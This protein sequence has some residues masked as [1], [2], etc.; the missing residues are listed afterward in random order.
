[1]FSQHL[2]SSPYSN[3]L[4][5]L[6][7]LG[8]GDDAY[9]VENLEEMQRGKLQGGIQIIILH[10]HQWGVSSRKQQTVQL[11]EGKI[12]SPTCRDIALLK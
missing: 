11:Q 6:S 1:M 7:L 3:D 8:N 5:L 9:Q 4:L 10:V 12:Y 2:L